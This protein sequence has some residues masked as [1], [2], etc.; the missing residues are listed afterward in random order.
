MLVGAYLAAGKEDGRG[1]LR[2]R[3]RTLYMERPA[4]FNNIKRRFLKGWTA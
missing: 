4:A 1:T 3:Y 2:G